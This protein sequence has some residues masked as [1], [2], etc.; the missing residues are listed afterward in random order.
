M[1]SLALRTLQPKRIVRTVK[2]GE[3]AAE[4][5]IASLFDISPTSSTL[6]PNFSSSFTI[7]ALRG[8]DSISQ[9]QLAEGSSTSYPLRRSLLLS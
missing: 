8:I 7:N 2:S 3:P 1:P 4:G 5:I 6:W 9:V